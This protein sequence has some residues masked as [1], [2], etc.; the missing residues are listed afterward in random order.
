M[1]RRSV[2]LLILYTC[3]LSA[4]GAADLVPQEELTLRGALSATLANYPQSRV[5]E[6]RNEALIG[7]RHTAELR[8]A[9]RVSSELENIV[10]TGDLN[11][12]QGNE[13]TLS[14]SQVI[15]LGDKRD[16]RVNIV[17]RRQNFL[18]AEQKV[19]ELDLL[20]ETALR[21]IELAAAEERLTLLSRA[22]LLAQDILDSVSE[23]V[24]A[25]AAPDSE[26]SRAGAALSLARL[27]ESSASYSISAARVRLSS[28]WGVL[29]PAF[30]NTSADLL[31]IEATL[32]IEDLLDNIET[33]PAIQ[34]FA[35]EERLRQ[36]ELREADSRRS[37][38]I[39][40]GAGIR[41]LESL[42]DSAFVLQFSMPLNSRRRAQGAISTAQANLYAVESERNLA[43]LQMR[44]S[45]IAL[46]QERKLA[47]E[48]VTVLRDIILPQLSSALDETQSL[49]EIGRYSYLELSAAQR[50]LLDA[51][52]N[53]IE[54]ATRAHLLRTEMERLSGESLSM[55]LLRNSQ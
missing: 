49:F 27:A 47:T 10:G 26:Q 6:F 52:F 37:A 16:A 2:T 13:L 40:L 42:N 22:T 7:E 31:S 12:L 3:T 51:E 25:G 50:E 28:Q 14:L 38:N 39:E 36:A 34:I 43:L 21:F 8:P 41:H 48:R 23:R 53:L 15:E 30:T 29:E 35:S 33:N 24:A 55:T 17:G 19:L 32:P 20:S 9:M 45:L 11:W 44:A 18:R 4:A 46:D 1:S 54:A 5:Y